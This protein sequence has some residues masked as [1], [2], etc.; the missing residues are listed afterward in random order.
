MEEPIQFARTLTT[1]FSTYEAALTDANPVFL[2]LRARFDRPN[3]PTR[4]VVTPAL[5]ST[6]DFLLPLVEFL[7][8]LKVVYETN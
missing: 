6:Y 7:A 8:T 3:L 2:D 1:S 5:F 4:D